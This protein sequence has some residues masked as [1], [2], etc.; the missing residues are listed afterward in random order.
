MTDQTQQGEA[1]QGQVQ[2]QSSEKKHL[3][4]DSIE[5][6]ADLKRQLQKRIPGYP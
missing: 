1:F 6:P 3:G 4:K 5:D 2:S